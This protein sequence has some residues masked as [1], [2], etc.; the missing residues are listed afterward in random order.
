MTLLDTPVV[1]AT[2]ILAD[3]Q[4]SIRRHQRRSLAQKLTELD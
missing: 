3:D 4:T 2:T 1:P